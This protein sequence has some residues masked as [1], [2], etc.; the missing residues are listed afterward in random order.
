[1]DWTI[2]KAAGLILKHHGVPACIV[3]ELVLNYYNVPRVCNELQICVPK[4]SSVVAA[5]LLCSTGLFEPFELVHDG[6]TNNYTEYKRGF[7]HLRTTDWVNPARTLIIFPAAFFGL[8][9]IEKVLIQL[10]SD[11]RFHISKEV[12]EDLDRDA[13][14]NLPLPQLAPLLKGLAKRYLETS[15][16]ISMIA[17]EQL[18][19][20]MNPDELWVQDHLDGSDPGVAS[21]VLDLVRGKESRIDYYSENKITCFVR[22]E[23]EAEA[24]RLIPGYE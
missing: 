1:M 11:R 24:V 10:P 22:D 14:A 2:V 13:I 7:P 8:D 5:G 17:I 18:V 16:D 19:D 15:D 4:S 9:P 6:E 21:L 12:Q 23:E 20:G 3:G